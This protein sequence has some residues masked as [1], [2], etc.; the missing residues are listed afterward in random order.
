[1]NACLLSIRQPIEGHIVE[2]YLTTF[3]RLSGA[4]TLWWN[5]LDIFVFYTISKLSSK[6]Q[7]NVFRG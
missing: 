2:L 6:I 4:P 5:T 7:P 1:M 3:N